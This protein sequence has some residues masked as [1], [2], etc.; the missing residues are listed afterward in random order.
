MKKLLVRSALAVLLGCFIAVSL[1]AQENPWI[2]RVSVSLSAGFAG[3][4]PFSCACVDRSQWGV[5]GGV[6]ALWLDL[7]GLDAEYGYG[8]IVYGFSGCASRHDL[9]MGIRLE[10]FHS[11]TGWWTGTFFRLGG[12]LSL[13]ESTRDPVFWNAIF[14]PGIALAP[15]QAFSLTFELP[16]SVTF[17]SIGHLTFGGLA[18]AR[19]RF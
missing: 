10:P 13:I 3:Y 6:T 7:V 12:G 2:P 4:L 14:S 15:S 11:M 17:G 16:V 1:P 18:G 5:R 8:G 9:M 19:L